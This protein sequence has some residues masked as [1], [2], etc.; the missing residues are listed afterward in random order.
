MASGS[1]P[2]ASTYGT[3]VEQ[4]ELRSID[5]DTLWD[6]SM[7][8]EIQVKLRDP[9]T[10][11]DELVLRLSNGSVT[12]P[13]P[14]IV[15]WRAEA[16]T[17]GSLPAKTYEGIILLQDATDTVPFYMGPISIVGEGVTPL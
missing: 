14:G 3:W 12:L 4:V 2:T 8:T 16:G 1:L 15:Q 9:R 7:F 11:N 13:A 17:M 5:D 10:G 6:T